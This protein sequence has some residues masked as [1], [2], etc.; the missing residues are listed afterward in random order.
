M[1]A[2]QANNQDVLK[3]MRDND[4]FKKI[5]KLSTIPHSVRQF[6]DFFLAFSLSTSSI[7]TWVEA[8]MSL[9]S[10]C[11]LL[12]Y[13][14]IEF[15]YVTYLAFKSDWLTFFSKTWHV[16]QKSAYIIIDITHL[17]NHRTNIKIATTA[18][19]WRVTLPYQISSRIIDLIKS[20]SILNRLARY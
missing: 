20:Y 3:L 4:R 12:Q 8:K 7:S 16:R 13:D 15:F 5:R 2:I 9:N 14:E 1:T 19:C 11:L 10:F 6:F 18:I 17:I